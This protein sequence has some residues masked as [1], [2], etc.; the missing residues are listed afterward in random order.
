MSLRCAICAALNSTIQIM[1]LLLNTVFPT[2]F[3]LGPHLSTIAKILFFL[4]SMIDVL[5]IDTFNTDSADYCSALTYDK[6]DANY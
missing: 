1:N 3:H 2:F 4:L 5:M 6:S